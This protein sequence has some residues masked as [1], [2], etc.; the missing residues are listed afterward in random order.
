[1]AK[2]TVTVKTKVTESSRKSSAPITLAK[3]AP[4]AVLGIL[5]GLVL[6]FYY[7]ILF[8]GK[9]LWEDFVEQEFPFRTLAASSLA[10]G[11][12]PQW[13]PYVFCGMPFVADI[14]VAFWYPMNMVQSFF[15]SDGHLSPVVMQW[16]IILH[17]FV[18]AAGMFYLVKQIFKTDDWS[19]LFAAIVYAFSGYLTAQ[20]M[21]QMIVYQLALFPFVVL[22]FLRGCDSWKHSIGA[23]LVLGAM[24]LAGHPQTSLFLTFFL[25]LLAV[26]EIVYRIR[27]KGDQKFSAI[28]IARMA[29]M[30]VIAVGLFAIEL[31]PSQELAALSQR[32]DITFDKSVEGSLYFGHLITLVL[33]RLF[34]VTDGMHEARVQ[35]WHGPNYLSWETMCYI[36]IMPLVLAIIAAFSGKRKYVAFFGGMSLFAVLFSLGDHFFLYKIFFQLP[37]FSK[38]RTPARMM[39]VFTFAMS[40]LAGLGLS[41]AIKKEI[42]DR[43]RNLIY[44]I[45]GLLVLLWLSSILWLFTP[46]SFLPGAPPDAAR[47]FTWAAELAAFPLF[48]TLV[49]IIL[50][51]RK[52]LAGMPLALAVIAVTTIELFTY[53]MGLNASSED[54]RA[55]YDEQPQL[56]QQL[57]EDQAKELSRAR[58]RSA[59]AMLLKR[60][61]G[62][63]DRIQLLEGY[64]PLVLQRNAPQCVN[65]DITA[66]LLNIKWTVEE[67][68]GSAGFVQRNTYLPR[69]KMYYKISVHSDEEAKKILRTDSTFDYRN[70]MLLE[71]K[72]SIMIAPPRLGASPTF[73]VADAPWRGGVGVVDSVSLTN[74]NQPPPNPR[75][76]KEGEQE[77]HVTRFEEN[78]IE[79]KV[80]TE[81][82]GMLFFSEVYYPAWHAYIDGKETKLYRAFTSLRAVEVP[83]GDHIIILKYESDAFKTGSMVTL[84]TLGLSLIGLGFFFVKKPKKSLL[85][86]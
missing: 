17:Y 2:Q 63:Y 86:D 85:T 59:H 78:E 40:A 32:N 66:D 47:S 43:L 42:P 31:L 65:P 6:I 70:V 50:V 38:L 15:V 51:A 9:F 82:N 33:P 29:V 79:A 80:S 24:Y 74:Q 69:V 22:L 27:N 41:Q 14:Q 55:A 37:L 57:K 28:I 71:E 18:A 30:M 84:G 83:K 45:G 16:F 49:I 10:A 35:Y 68:G 81:V 20:P 12:I 44:G 61:A 3:I 26:Y 53:G 77:A 11:H 34:G 67:K 7:P 25:A 36:G 4:L 39:M 48:A 21:H 52:K 64:N 5:L 1:M 76:E 8:G 72:P 56:V 23:G 46:I 19:A 13:N 54:P 62:A 60:N 73:Q 75:L 58:I